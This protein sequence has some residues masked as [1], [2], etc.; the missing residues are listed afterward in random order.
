MGNGPGIGK[1]LSVQD[2]EDAAA[3]AI[4]NFGKPNFIMMPL[5]AV[6][7]YSHIMNFDMH[8]EYAGTP[9]ASMGKLSKREQRVAAVHTILKKLGALKNISEEEFNTIRHHS[10]KRLKRAKWARYHQQKKSK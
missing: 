5:Q 7:A 2:I 3:Q 1:T 10:V 6:Q 4:A 9:W 8:P